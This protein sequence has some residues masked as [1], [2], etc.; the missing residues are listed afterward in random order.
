MI[1]GLTIAM[2]VVAIILC[3]IVAWLYIIQQNKKPIKVQLKQEH[4]PSYQESASSYRSVE[5]KTITKPTKPFHPEI[6]TDYKINTRMG[7]TFK[8]NAKSPEEIQEDQRKR[9]WNN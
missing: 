4:A 3:V 8:G 1:D 9:D 2:I 6:L 7:T 5:K